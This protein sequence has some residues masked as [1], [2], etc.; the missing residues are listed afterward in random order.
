MDNINKKYPGYTYYSA[1]KFIEHNADSLRKNKSWNSWEVEVKDNDIL[2]FLDD[3]FNP[4]MPLKSPGNI[5]SCYTLKAELNGKFVQIPAWRL[6]DSYQQSEFEFT[7]EYDTLSRTVKYLGGAWKV[8]SLNVHLKR[9]WFDVILLLLSPAEEQIRA[10]WEIKKLDIQMNMVI[11][12][13]K[14]QIMSHYANI[15]RA[16]TRVETIRIKEEKVYRKTSSRFTWGEGTQDRDIYDVTAEYL[17]KTY[18]KDMLL[19][20]RVYSESWVE[21]E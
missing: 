5:D 9:Y 7:N 16:N 15:R 4:P 20:E 3:D 19:K 1:T 6:F 21:S 18:Y 2:Y 8:K 13:Y 12:A 10:N 14:S 17:E 11:D